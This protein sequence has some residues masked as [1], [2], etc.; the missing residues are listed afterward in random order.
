M[1][2]DINAVKELAL[3]KEE[4]IKRYE[5]GYDKKVI[6]QFINELFRILDFI[7][8]EQKKEFTESLKEI[9]ED[10]TLLLENNGINKVEIYE[11]QNLEDLKKFVK[12]IKTENTNIE[13]IDLT[14]ND[15]LKDG[16]F[17]QVD[18]ETTHVIRYAEVIINKYEGNK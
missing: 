9:E 17:I 1:K 2:E 16:W 15:I 12:V 3:S 4:K 14:I 6:N 11:S 7:K 8:D 5:E 10:I 18:N 13:E